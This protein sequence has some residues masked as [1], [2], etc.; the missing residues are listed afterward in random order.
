MNWAGKNQVN[1]MKVSKQHY[2]CRKCGADGIITYPEDA[3]VTEVIGI[4]V[5]DH[6]VRSPDCTARSSKDFWVKWL[7]ESDDEPG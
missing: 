6:E 5:G 4:M 7:D 1:S 3:T 2:H